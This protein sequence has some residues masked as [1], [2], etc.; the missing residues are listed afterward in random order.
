VEQEDG[1]GGGEEESATSLPFFPLPP[2][3]SS[4]PTG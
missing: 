4:N 2:S 3:H 1:N